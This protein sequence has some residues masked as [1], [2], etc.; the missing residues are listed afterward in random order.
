[1][2]LCLLGEEL[3]QLQVAPVAVKPCCSYAPAVWTW[4]RFLRGAE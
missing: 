2:P 4:M 3:D 1:M